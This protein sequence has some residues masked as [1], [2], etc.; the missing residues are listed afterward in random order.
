MAV[1]SELAV[2]V[3]ALIDLKIQLLLYAT[4]LQKTICYLDLWRWY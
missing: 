1:A 3:G 2:A 4:A